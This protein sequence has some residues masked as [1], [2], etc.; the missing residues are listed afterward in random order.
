MIQKPVEIAALAKLVLAI[1][2]GGSRGA[3]GLFLPSGSA[4]SAP[5]E[6]SGGTRPNGENAGS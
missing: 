6:E 5:V 3:D 1:R 2:D 4:I